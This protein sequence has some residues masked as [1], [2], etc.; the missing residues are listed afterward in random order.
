MTAL[1]VVLLIA[2]SI[3]AVLTALVASTRGRSVP[4]WAAAGFFFGPLALFAVGFMPAL[5]AAP[6]R[7]QRKCPECAELILREARRCKHC[8]ATVSPEHATP[9][10]AELGA[11]NRDAREAAVQ[12]ALAGDSSALDRLASQAAA[13]RSTAAHGAALQSPARHAY[14]ATVVYVALGLAALATVSAL[15]LS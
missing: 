13:Q 10:A 2:W 14:E 5:A 11:V 9:A 3:V 8:G 1:A 4:G 15:L 6:S 7:S 12:A